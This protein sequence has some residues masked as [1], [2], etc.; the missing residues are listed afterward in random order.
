MTFRSL[1]RSSAPRSTLLVRLL[2]GAVFLSEGIQKFLYPTTLGVGR[3][4]QIGIPGPSLVAPFVGGVEI[5]FGTLLLLGLATRVATL[6]LLAVIATAIATTKIPLLSSQGFWAIGPR[7]TGRLVHA[8]RVALP[9]HRRRRSMVTRRTMADLAL[10][11]HRVRIMR[12]HRVAPMLLLTL[13]GCTRGTITSATY[14]PRTR[15]ITIA[16]VPLLVKE[17][18]D[19]YPF[20]QGAF[21]KGGVLQGK[22]VYAFS[23]STIT[24]VEG[25]TLR[26]TLINPED[27]QHSFVLPDLA[28]PLPGGTSTEVTYVA[29]HPGIYPVVCAVASHL[30]MMTGQLVVLST[31]AVTETTK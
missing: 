7:S 27:D 18:Q 9:R 24:V 29:M 25:D 17:E 4:T 30:P 14:V 22:E 28:V 13:A 21:A 10:T 6:P 15:K 31:R 11:V 12:M 8:A 5:A 16:T 26:L 20:L 23:P 2:V 19:V 3:F 1:F